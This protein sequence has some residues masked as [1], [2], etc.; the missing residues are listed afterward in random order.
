MYTHQ[1]VKESDRIYK[2]Y[3]NHRILFSSQVARSIGLQQQ[4]TVIKIGMEKTRG[5][6]VSATMDDIVVLTKMSSNLQK[7]IYMENGMVTVQLKF[8]DTLFKKE[9]A[10]NLYTKFLNMNNHGLPTKEMQ[11]LS[12]KFRRRIPH[13]LISVFGK[14]HE[15]LS[16]AATVLNKNAE[17]MLFVRGIR[18]ACFPAF[19]DKEKVLINYL[20]NPQAFIQHKAMLVLK[21]TETGETFEVIGK[22]DEEFKKLVDAFQLKLNY[23]IDQQ[24]PRFSNSLGDLTK[25]INNK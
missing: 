14:H 19:I 25:L 22:I 10:F 4:D 7:K 20:G 16:S 18:K 1:E 2:A 17:G 12:L 13:D 5:A 3:Q 9:M 24:S 21:S 6:L 8:Y 15:K 23:S 11:Y